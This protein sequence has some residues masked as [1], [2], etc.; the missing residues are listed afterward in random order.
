MQVD[1][2]NEVFNVLVPTIDGGVRE[3]S[4]SR[5]EYFS[6]IA[7]NYVFESK[8]GYIN[9]S[10][11]PR[12]EVL[13]NL[14][15]GI[16]DHI[17]NIRATRPEFPN[18]S[19]HIIRSLILGASAAKLEE[20]Y[21]IGINLATRFLME[22]L[23]YRMLSSNNI[24]K[25]FG[26]PT[27]EADTQKVN[28]ATN[29]ELNELIKEKLPNEKIY[30]NDPSRAVLAEFLVAI[31]IK[32]L[33]VHE[34]AHVIFGH[35]DYK[36]GLISEGKEINPLD[37]QTLEYDADAYAVKIALQEIF[38][39][40]ENKGQV[41]DEIISF[42]EDIETAI[43]IWTFAIYSLYRLYQKHAIDENTIHLKSHPP[44]GV[45]QRIVFGMI[46][47]LLDNDKYRYL[48]P[49]LDYILSDVITQVEKAF[50]EISHQG[51][52]KGN[53]RFA[54]TPK[55]DAHLKAI[56]NNWAEVRPRLEVFSYAKLAPVDQFG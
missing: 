33:S 48:I 8:G 46:R 20:E 10:E 31:S 47:V 18:P 30:P 49:K 26:N 24:L 40:V 50:E 14:I 23:F 12:E 41:R 52:C 19:V 55:A 6:T 9:P 43:F 13:N 45:R 2:V 11:L 28:Y 34:Y 51:L 56:H 53:I 35:V 44:V 54:F 21:Y 39:L 4:M 3:I 5:A 17:S 37:N 16:R 1:G 25:Q 42:Y 22:D 15:R 7:F 27:L 38:F 36:M 32:Y 29:T